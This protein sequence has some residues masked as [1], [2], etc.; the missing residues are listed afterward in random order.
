RDHPLSTADAADA[1]VGLSLDAPVATVT[2]DSPHN[3]N[4]L[5]R[6][7]VD[8]LRAALVRADGDPDIRVVVLTHTGSTFCAGADM[9]EAIADG[10]ER[11]SRALLDLLTL[12][13]SMQT[14]VVALVRGHVRAGGLGLVGAC[15][16]A[17]VTE[18]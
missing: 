9:A 4:A 16:V 10:M 5:S 7:L 12:V 6:R 14:P 11:G 17:L 18:S 15:D 2:L 3:R 8:E 1:L 13:V